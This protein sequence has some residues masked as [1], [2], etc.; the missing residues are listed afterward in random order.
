MPSTEPDVPAPTPTAGR[1]VGGVILAVVAVGGLLRLAGLFGDLWLDEIWSV[2]M[3]EAL[4][5]PLEVLTVLRHDNNHPLN[6]LWLYAVGSGAPAWWMRLP[7]WIAGTAAVAVAAAVGRAQARRLDPD[8]PPGAERAGV[9]AAGALAIAY[10]FVHYASEAR[11]YSA[12]VFLALVAFLA[13]LRFTEDGGPGEG[14]LR[15]AAAYAGASILAIL[16][17]PTAAVVLVGGLVLQVDAARRPRASPLGSVLAAHGLPSLA[18]AAFVWGFVRPMVLG[19]GPSRGVVEVLGELAAYTLGLD[20]SL[21]L[22]LALPLLVGALAT[23]LAVVARRSPGL[24]LAY[25]AMIVVAPEVGALAGRSAGP[26]PRYFLVP[27]AFALMAVS[28]GAARLWATGRRARW[29][30]A[31]AAILVAVGCTVHTTA[32]A[33]YG[34]GRYRAALRHMA[35]SSPFPEITLTSDH[36]FRNGT[37]AAWHADAAGPDRT[38]VYLP[39]DGLPPRGAQWTLVQRLH[40]EPPPGKEVHDPQGHRY[41]LDGTYPYAGLSGWEWVVY[42]NEALPP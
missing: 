2:R 21:G 5:S 24:A 7:A 30:V 8:D 15:W 11:G 31:A 34:R 20:P 19:G 4:D 27:T 41:E 3:V 14:S 37:V 16:A 26:F 32:L 10:P 42:R 18:L 35:A 13:I 33:R 40:G 36:D 1:G 25:V 6:S 38:V 28:Y 9:A 39:A 29:G 17:H 12:A 23:A 22:P